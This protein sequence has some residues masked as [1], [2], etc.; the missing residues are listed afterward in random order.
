[1]EMIERQKRSISQRFV[2]KFWRIFQLT[3]LKSGNIAL[4]TYYRIAKNNE[5]M[6]WSH[7]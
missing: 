7:K 1:M 2:L 3:V 5:I 4:Y 6:H